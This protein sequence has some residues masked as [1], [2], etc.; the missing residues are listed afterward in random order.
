MT[1]KNVTL[2]E[3][4]GH[5]NEL[6]ERVVQGDEIIITKGDRPCA[7]LVAMPS[8]SYAPRVFGQH[9]GKARMSDDFDAS[10]PDGFW[11]GSGA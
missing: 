11:L 4:E 8:V 7:R 10:L 9:K 1:I 6:L 3:A 5:L 2:Q